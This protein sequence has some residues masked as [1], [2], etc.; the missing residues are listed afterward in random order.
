MAEVFRIPSDRQPWLEPGTNIISRP[1]FLFLQ[2]LFI[3]SGGS[4][5]PSSEA[6]DFGVG[7][8]SGADDM[9]GV[10][11]QQIQDLNLAPVVQQLQE[12]NFQLTAELTS[13][14]DELSELRRVVEGIQ[15][16]TVI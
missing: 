5:G 7:P 4:T 2:G 11:M 12:Q 1:W 15:A 14:R 8:N 9:A 10:F 6:L 13:T 16:G 3:R